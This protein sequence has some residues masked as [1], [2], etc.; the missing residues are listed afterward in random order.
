[1]RNSHRIVKWLSLGF[2]IFGAVQSFAAS[3]DCAK[4]GTK[5]EK[6][7][8][9]TP[10]LNKLDSDLA[11][12]YKEAV[13]KEPS[14]KQEQLSWMKERNKCSTEACLE[15][16]YRDRIDDLINFI[17]RSDREAMKRE[18]TKSVAATPSAPASR[19][20][21]TAPTYRPPAPA[22]VQAQDP[23]NIYLYCI[24]NQF[25]ICYTTPAECEQNRPYYGNAAQCKAEA[26]GTSATLASTGACKRKGF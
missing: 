16:S 18:Q 11:S 4:A 14:I 13:A 1:M 12:S 23:R 9:A 6:M 24:S 22:P 19:P 7:I 3:F 5:V 15:S 2:L 25:G 10:V 8:C 21:E 20:S 17:V 26:C